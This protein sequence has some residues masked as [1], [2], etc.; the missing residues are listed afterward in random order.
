[1]HQELFESMAQSIIAG[2]SDFAMGFAKRAIA[3]GINP[4]IASASSF[5]KHGNNLI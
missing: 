5:V 4:L 2:D 1:M 3:A